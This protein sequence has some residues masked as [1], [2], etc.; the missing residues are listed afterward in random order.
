MTG[1]S[2]INLA[3]ESESGYKGAIESF[4]SFPPGHMAPV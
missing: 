1:G 4:P 2:F 3:S